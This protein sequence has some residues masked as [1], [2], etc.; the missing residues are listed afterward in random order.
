[1]NTISE[2][3]AAY[4]AAIESEAKAAAANIVRNR[5][6]TFGDTHREKAVVSATYAAARAA[7]DSAYAVAYVA[8]RV[9][10]G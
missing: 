6:A 4:D 2:L 5:N 8:R 1:M 3:A 7:S 9:A 10:S